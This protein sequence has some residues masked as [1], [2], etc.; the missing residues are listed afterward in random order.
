L[1]S[2]KPLELDRKTVKSLRR[3]GH[4]LA[5]FQRAQ[6]SIYQRSAKGKLPAWIAE[7]L[8]VG[9]PDWMIESQR[10]SGLRGVLPRVIRPDL[11]LTGDENR[12]TFALTE[13]DSVP[14]GMGITLWLSRIY[15]E[16]GFDVL[17][18]ADGIR[19]GF[20]SIFPEGEEVDVLISEESADY[21]AEMEYLAAQCERVFVK[22]AEM[23]GG[24]ICL[25]WHIVFLSGLIGKTSQW[26]VSL[27]NLPC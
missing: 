15:S 8:D 24:R 23:T 2:P 4:P 18:G 27:Q 26:R 10:S 25:L 22:S 13:L 12:N 14:G 1:F 20:E 11:I 9:K 17:G 21:R 6:E 7:L 16:H 3:L 19:H 5:Q